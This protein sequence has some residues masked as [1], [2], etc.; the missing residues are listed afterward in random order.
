MVSTDGVRVLLAGTRTRA[1]VVERSVSWDVKRAERLPPLC[2]LAKNVAVRPVA[3]ALAS[4]SVSA[5][6]V[7]LGASGRFEISGDVK[8]AD[9]SSI[10]SLAAS[11]CECL[12]VEHSVVDGR[13]DDFGR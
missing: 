3:R 10:R 4:R 5:E 8:S 7:P 6:E 11:D 1:H 2:P 9:S 13:I 12:V